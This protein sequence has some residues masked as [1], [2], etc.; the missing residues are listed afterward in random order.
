[1]AFPPGHPPRLHLAQKPETQADDSECFCCPSIVRLDPTLQK[2]KKKKEIA[3]ISDDDDVKTE[4][5]TFAHLCAGTISVRIAD[6]VNVDDRAAEIS[7]ETFGMFK[8]LQI[9]KAGLLTV[10]CLQPPAVKRKGNSGVSGLDLE[11]D[12]GVDD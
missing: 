8:E 9:Q 10:V 1:M 5:P 2:K 4:H 3:D 11:E 6:N 12:D 7:N